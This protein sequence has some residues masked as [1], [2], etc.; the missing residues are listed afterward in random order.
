MIDKINP[1]LRSIDYVDGKKRSREFYAM[2]PETAYSILETIAVLGGRR[3]RL[4]LYE[5]TEQEQKSEDL[6]QE[7]EE[8][9]VERLSPFAFSKCD[10]LFLCA[11][12]SCNDENLLHLKRYISK[13]CILT[14]V[15]SVKTGI[16]KQI[17][18]LGL[19][20]LFI[21]GHPMA[22]SERYGYANSKA[23]LL[24][25]AYYILTPSDKVPA[26]KLELYK[27]LITS[28]GAIPLILS[29]EQHDYV[30]AAVSP[31]PH[32]VASSL[33][34]L[35]RDSD[36]K[37][38]IMKMIAAGGFKDITRIAS[39]S[40]HIRSAARTDRIMLDVIIAL[41]PT[42][43]VGTVI[44]RNGKSR[45]RH[46]L[47]HIRIFGRSRDEHPAPVNFRRNAVC[48]KL[49]AFRLHSPHAHK[50]SLRREHI[51]SDSIG[52][53]IQKNGY[54]VFNIFVINESAEVDS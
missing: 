52:N 16:H 48:A 11:P 50:Q 23:K 44:F 49:H 28:I 54:I 46:L 19:E 21:G 32:V 25:N 14:D 30:T 35:V 1:N 8:E 33:V 7:I 12:V 37:N 6:S 29:Y 3:D 53:G 5:M 43:I 20:H 9:N 26:V 15:G 36:S 38:G 17:A 47:S 31:L 2:S 4:Q 39:S 45:R 13:D 34:N 41:L 27:E 10:I 42:T 40:P 24:E 22:G 18:A 51:L